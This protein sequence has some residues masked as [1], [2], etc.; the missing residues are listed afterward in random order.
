VSLVVLE[1][2]EAIFSPSG[3][4]GQV[5]LDGI[6]EEVMDHR[7]ERKGGRKS[8]SLKRGGS[9]VTADAEGI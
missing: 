8:C 9:R 2:G 7:V 3:F 5:T 1:N 4:R 6:G